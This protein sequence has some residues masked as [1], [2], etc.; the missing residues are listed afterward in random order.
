MARPKYVRIKYADIPAD[1]RDEYKL[2]DYKHNGWAY[3]DVICGAYG[4]LQSG[5]LAND[6][7]RTRLN[8]SG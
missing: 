7:L 1:F 2:A 6:L 4:L 5:K 3:F 8:K